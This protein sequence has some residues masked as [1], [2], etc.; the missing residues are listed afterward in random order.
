MTRTFFALG[1]KCGARG[2][3]GC[4]GD[5]CGRMGDLSAASR[6]C[7]ASK[8]T[9]AIPLNPVP[10]RRRKSRRLS[11]QRPAWEACHLEHI[12]KLIDI[13]EPTEEE[14]QALFLAQF[15]ACLQ[16]FAIRFALEGQRKRAPHLRPRLLARLRLQSLGEEARLLQDKTA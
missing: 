11:S 10:P 9:S 2:A 7:S 1:A 12:D 4:S 16:F 3:L 8:E 15:G 6:R 14:H 5:H 13:E